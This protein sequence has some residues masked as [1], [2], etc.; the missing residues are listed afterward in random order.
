MLH[1]DHYL[2]RMSYVGA[3]PIDLSHNSPNGKA[4]K[5]KSNAT[6]MHTFKYSISDIEYTCKVLEMKNGK[7]I[8]YTVYV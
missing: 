2:S 6:Q 8:A 7:L 5:L 4:Y 1:L 3:E